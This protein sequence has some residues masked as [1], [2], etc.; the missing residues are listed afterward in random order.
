[1]I[2]PGTS[3]GTR[4]G[5]RL[6]TGP[7]TGLDTG[8]GAWALLA[9]AAAFACA[10]PEAGIDRSEGAE[11]LRGIELEAP[12]AAPEFGLVDTGGRRYEFRRETAGSLTLLFFGYTWCPD[13]CPV[14]MA[15]LSR[16]LDDLTYADRREIEV[17]FVTTDPARDTPERMRAWLDRFGA[18]FVGLRGDLDA[19]NGIQ[20]GFRLPP[21]GIEGEPPPAGSDEPYFVG[22]ATPILAITGDGVVRAMYPSGVRQTDWRHDLPLLLDLHRTV[23]RR[24]GAAG[25]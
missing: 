12:F 10:A 15:V 20:A 8:P 9:A 3:P 6:D 14:Q 25:G 17:V 24:D 13:I 1:M 11:G 7:G 21:A 22:H 5:T 19:V 4:P 16:A 2:P 23:S 18:S